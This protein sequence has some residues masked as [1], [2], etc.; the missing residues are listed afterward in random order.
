LI[1]L[2]ISALTILLLL[3]VILILFKNPLLELV[4][5]LLPS[6]QHTGPHA[7]PRNLRKHLA[8]QNHNNA[9]QHPPDVDL[10]GS[11][12]GWGEEETAEGVEEGKRLEKLVVVEDHF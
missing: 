2:S 8:L 11:P 7:P 9:D 5:P 4:L 12:D 3:I 1:F 10:S 6:P